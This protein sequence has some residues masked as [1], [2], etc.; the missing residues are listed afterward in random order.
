MKLEKFLKEKYPIQFKNGV[1]EVEEND[2]F[3]MIMSNGGETLYLTKQFLWH[4]GIII[5]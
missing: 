2:E 5:N 1:R 3:V 4:E